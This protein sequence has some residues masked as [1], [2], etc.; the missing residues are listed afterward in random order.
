MINVFV[1][2]VTYNGFEW[3][4]KWFKSLLN[5]TIPLKIIVIDNGSVDGTCEK[6]RKHFAEVDLIE[7]TSNLGFGQAN[8][9]G[10]KKAYDLGA[11]HFFLLNQ[12][13]WMEPDTIEKLI[14]K[15]KENNEFG[16]LS[17][18]H[19]N[20]R[21]DALDSNFSTCIIPSKC[22]SLYSDFYLNSIQDK[23]YEIDFVNAAAWLLS[24]KCIEKVG[25]F[26]PSFFQYGEDDN[27]IHRA[28]YFGVKVGIYPLSKIFHDRENRNKSIYDEPLEKFKRRNLSKYSNPLG[29]YNIDSD[30]RRLIMS[31]TLQLLQGHIDSFKFVR[32]Q[33]KILNEIAPSIKE[34]LS[35]SIKGVPLCFLDN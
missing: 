17:P 21:G 10:I 14:I 7:S 4:D 35:R 16:I 28:H 27:Y 12:D 23:I 22:R 33:Y 26:S 31:A 8:N 9:I 19:L 5:S 24:R 18:V 2:I 34:N 3:V 25:G 1:I 6:I 20:G 15:Q 32:K 30:K 11:T 29:K 13:A